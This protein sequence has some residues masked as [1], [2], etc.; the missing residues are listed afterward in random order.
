MS[1]LQPQPNELLTTTIDHNLL[2]LRNF[3]ALENIDLIKSCEIV[4]EVPQSFVGVYYIVRKLKKIS[5]DGILWDFLAR[6]GKL[7]K[8]CFHAYSLM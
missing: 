7:E 1:L 5:F 8:V 2:I 3:G 4:F 6:S